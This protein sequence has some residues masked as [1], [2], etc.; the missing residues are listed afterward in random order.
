MGTASECVA[1]VTGDMEMTIS[2]NPKTNGMLTTSDVRFYNLSYVCRCEPFMLGTESKI[3][4]FNVGKT[5]SNTWVVTG[6]VMFRS[7]HQD[8]ERYNNTNADGSECEGGA[9]LP[10]VRESL[11]FLNV[12]NWKW[13]HDAPVSTPEGLKHCLTEI[14]ADGPD[15]LGDDISNSLYLGALLKCLEKFYKRGGS[16]GAKKGKEVVGDFFQK[17]IERWLDDGPRDLGAMNAMIGDLTHCDGS[18]LPP[19]I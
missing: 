7:V 15:A 3:G 5:D 4:P 16:R 10:E 17:M 19:Q 1:V 14:G 2:V 11:A 9:M 6:S 12:K 18:N 13:F 8:C